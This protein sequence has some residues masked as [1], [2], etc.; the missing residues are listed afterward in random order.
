[1]LFFGQYRVTAA[2]LFGW[3]ITWKILKS[4]SHP[5]F[6]QTRD[7]IF[8]PDLQNRNFLFAQLELTSHRVLHHNFHLRNIPF[9]NRIHFYKGFIHLRKETDLIKVALPSR[10]VNMSWK[11]ATEWILYFGRNWRKS[12]L[13]QFIQ[14]KNTSG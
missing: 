11:V 4:R 12:F 9:Y 8:C 14:N 10:V 6:V 13:C 7:V 2:P 5:Y 3:L 1:M